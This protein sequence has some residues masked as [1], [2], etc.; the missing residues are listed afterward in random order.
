M[1][2]RALRTRAYTQQLFHASDVDVEAYPAIKNNTERDKMAVKS[3]W[4]YMKAFS[5][6]DQCL[7]HR[8]RC[9]AQDT[10]SRTMGKHTDWSLS[11]NGIIQYA[12]DNTAL[13]WLSCKS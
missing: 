1:S 5:F 13:I 9:A 4:R 12:F 3:F 10:S 8:Y 11:A 7:V 6:R 2:S